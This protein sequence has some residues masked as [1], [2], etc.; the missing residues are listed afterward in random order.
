MLTEQLRSKLQA[1]LVDV[2]CSIKT[3]EDDKKLQMSAISEHIKLLKKRQN[4]ISKAIKFDDDEELIQVFGE[5]YQNELGL[6]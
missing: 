1:K 4:A 3:T 6:K 5:F 2:T